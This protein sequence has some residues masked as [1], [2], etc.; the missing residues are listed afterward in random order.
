MIHN[1]SHFYLWDLYQKVRLDISYHKSSNLYDSDLHRMQPYS[2]GS[3]ILGQ[4]FQASGIRLFGLS[5]AT[6]FVYGLV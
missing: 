2:F 5:L 3:V 6:R 4:N 1:L